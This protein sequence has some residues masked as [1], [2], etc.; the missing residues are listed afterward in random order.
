MDKLAAMRAFVAVHDA[1]GFAAAVR[2]TGQSRAALNRMVMAL[3]SE[4]GVQLF[5][6]ST[7]HVA[8]TDV[9]RAYHDR[10][11]TVLGLLDDAERSLVE[12]RDEAR[13]DLRVNAP[14]SFGTMHLGPALADFMTRHPGVRIQLVLDDRFVAP[15]ADGYDLV[16]RIAAP[17]E[18]SSL[19]DHRI[20]E[21]RRVVC[22]SPG[23]VQREGAPAHPSEL[24]TRACLHYGNLATGNLWRLEGPDGPAEVAVG[25]VL[26]S[27]NAEIL[28]DVAVKGLGLALLPT[29]I[30]AGELRAGR[31]VGVLRD[32]H[33]TPLTLSAIY[34]PS[35]H[36][37]A[38]VR[39][40]T[41]FLIERFGGRP[42]WDLVE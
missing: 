1:G 25:G 40:L 26:C 23:Y 10:V 39:V 5:N 12:G 9:G 21:I 41:D 27:N 37:S 42:S 3:E 18:T 8:P 6:R 28:R 4:L 29:F 34:P 7:R 22:A 31:L 11:R 33:A 36:L 30:A 24:A 38:A 32:W 2:R 19:V 35:H 14:M 16:V 13:G 15:I 20:A 17:D